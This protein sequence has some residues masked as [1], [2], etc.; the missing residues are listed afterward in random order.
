MAPGSWLD[1][2]VSTNFMSPKTNEDAL[3]VCIDCHLTR[4]GSGIRIFTRATWGM[5]IL[6]W[7]LKR[8]MR[9]PALHENSMSA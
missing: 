9:I 3:E 4:G 8:V 1:P 6:V 5:W 2:S 7:F